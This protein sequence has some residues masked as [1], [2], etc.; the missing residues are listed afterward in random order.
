MR[1]IFSLV[2]L[3]LF[4]G[5]AQAQI[6]GIRLTTPKIEKKYKKYLVEIDGE[7]VICG[8]FKSGIKYEGGAVS[9][10][11]KKFIELWVAD[12]KS[13][14]KVP[15]R[16]DGAKKVQQGR[17]GV[18]KIARD[19]IPKSNYMKMVAR[20]QTFFGL[21]SEFRLRKE[22][23]DASE[24][25]VAGLK[26]ASTEWFN[27][28]RRLMGRCDRLAEWL[29]AGVFKK[30]AKTWRSKADKIR[31]LLKGDALAERKGK[32]LKSV[33]SVDNPEDLAEVSFKGKKFTFTTAESLHCRMICDI[34]IIPKKRAEELLVLAE[35]VI[36][37]FRREFV[38]PFAHEFEDTIPDKIFVE[39][40]YMGD[41]IDL[42]DTY[43]QEF[44]GRQFSNTRE[45]R[46]KTTGTR[47]QNARGNA[48]VHYSRFGNEG[49]FE[50]A[51]AHSLGHDL[52]NVHFNDDHFR[53]TMDWL[54]EGCAYYISFE[55]LGRNTVTCYQF[56]RGKYDS[57]PG[58]EGLK[59]LQTGQRASFN[60]LALKAALPLHALMPKELYEMQ[61]A[62]LAKSWS[63]F[64]YLARKQ[65]DKM[66][67][68]LR[69]ACQG[70]RK[71]GRLL[72]AVR[73]DAPPLFGLK[74]GVDVFKYLDEA[75]K[76]YARSG[77][78]RASKKKKRRR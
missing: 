43:W 6:V 31:S 78:K 22:A 44:Y 15:Y 7:N 11:G 16:L 42:Y 52:A 50:G 63:F 54:E 33:K 51:V 40:F 18:V 17:K 46:L 19:H 8:E 9:I 64:D 30:A 1:N 57:Q 72:N 67:E 23:I 3:V 39:F 60:A 14:E 68:F 56:K 37:G 58:A 35:K 53:G 25:K 28:Q 71:K 47:M 41:D 45:Q 34:K 76:T 32:A 29:S 61:D 69:I 74:P 66:V 12:P 36:E 4:L 38:D 27:A 65:T 59:T 5:S 48:Y 2:F 77:Q 10:F 75:W 24:A 55:F 26:K 62:D 21:A 20:D 73:E 49:D 70:A 13:P